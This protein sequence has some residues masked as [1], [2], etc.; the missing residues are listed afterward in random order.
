MYIRTSSYVLYIRIQLQLE[1]AIHYAAFV[2]NMLCQGWLNLLKVVGAQLIN[3][4][5]KNFINSYEHLQI[6]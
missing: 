4:T 2:S 5:V 1:L 3:K 6:L